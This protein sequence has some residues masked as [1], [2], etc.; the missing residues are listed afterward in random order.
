[1]DGPTVTIEESLYR[2]DRLVSDLTG[3]VNNVWFE[4]LKAGEP[5]VFLARSRPANVSQLCGQPALNFGDG[6]SME[7][8]RALMKAV[9]ESVERYCSAQY[10]KK[11]LPLSAFQELG[12]EA[13]DPRKFALFDPAQYSEPGFPFAPLTPETPLRW[14]RGFSLIHEREIFVPAAFVHV[15]Y[16][17][18]PP[19]EPAINNPISTGLACGSCYASAIYKGI[20]EVLERDAFM[21]SW[22]NQIAPVRIDLE[23]DPDP[24][25]RRLTEAMQGFPFQIHA[26]SI[27]L[28]IKVPIILVIVSNDTEVPPFTVIGLSA[29]L[30]PRRALISA[31]EEGYQCLLG[32]QEAVR[33]NPDF[34]PASDFHNVNNLDL[35]GLAQAVSPELRQSMGFLI[36]SNQ[37]VSID[38]IPNLFSESMVQNIQTLAN[39]VKKEGL[40]IIFVNLTTPDIDEVGFKVIRIVIPG[41]QPL[42]VNHNYR[43]LGGERLYQVPIKIGARNNLPGKHEFNP[44]PHPF[45]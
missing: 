44:Y 9:G 6:V 1:M 33:L 23:G 13:V 22:H 41:C 20:R 18:D 19:T 34:K 38:Q 45:P 15:P 39:L 25:V 35:H 21:I 40:D 5:P 30:H 14:V 17:F 43:H 36:E 3:I 28:D 29:D 8:N 31:L 4:E 2:A 7:P 24:Q 26:V 32:M 12:N 11:S 42:D 27:T 37:E 16:Q 10:D